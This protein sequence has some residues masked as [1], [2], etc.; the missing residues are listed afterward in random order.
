MEAKTETKPQAPGSRDAV[1]AE[2]PG[3][4]RFAPEVIE[5]P[6]PRAVELEGAV[7]VGRAKP[8]YQPGPPI[9][10]VRAGQAEL[11][12]GH[13][14]PEVAQVQ[15]RLH[16]LGF[17][18]AEDG[19]FGPKTRASV[20]AFQ[21]AHSLEERDGAVGPKTLAALERAFEAQAEAEMR[22]YANPQFVIRDGV[23]EGRLAALPTPARSA[24]AGLAR[25]G[26][27]RPED[28]RRLYELAT[29]REI[30]RAEPRVQLA[31][32]ERIAGAGGPEAQ[33][34]ALDRALHTADEGA[35]RLVYGLAALDL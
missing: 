23:G 21:A 10:A 34:A 20:Q 1:E 5:A 13:R 26:L 32:L 11:E 18:T 25:G 15:R 3:V 30:A 2:S 12:R 19:L 28:Q 6:A 27:A 29:S 33:R 24:I 35:L 7:I 9:S 16:A 4:L 22:P 8:R 31:V 14:G 17:A